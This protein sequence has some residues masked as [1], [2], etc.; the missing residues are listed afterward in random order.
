M[1]HSEKVREYM[2]T[3]AGARVTK[4][5]GDPGCKYLLYGVQAVGSG[6]MNPRHNPHPRDVIRVTSQQYHAYTKGNKFRG[7]RRQK[8]LRR[9]WKQVLYN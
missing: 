1:L 5:A 7:Q 2:T 3:G 8:K 6:W 4:L 9:V